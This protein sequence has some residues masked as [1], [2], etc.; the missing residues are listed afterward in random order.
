MLRFFVPLTLYVGNLVVQ[1]TKGAHQYAH[2]FWHFSV[3]QCHLLATHISQPNLPSPHSVNRSHHTLPTKLH[4]PPL[5]PYEGQHFP[6]RQSLPVISISHPLM[7]GQGS[8]TPTSPIPKQNS[9]TPTWTTQSPSPPFSPP[10]PHSPSN[11]SDLSICQADPQSQ[12]SFLCHC[13]NCP[14]P[15]WTICS[16]FAWGACGELPLAWYPQQWALKQNIWCATVIP[17][18]NRIL[19]PLT[20]SRHRNFGDV[21]A[22]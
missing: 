14:A 16:H 11:S 18:S 2:N 13:Q 7:P 21:R 12:A 20:K 9:H 22:N 8:P 1:W 10:I 15:T 4:Q 6:D 17:L 5:C 19:K 3:I